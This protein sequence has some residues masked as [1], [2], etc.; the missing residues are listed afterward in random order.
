MF[1]EMFMV[2]FVQNNGNDFLIL[3]V[4]CFR[5]SPDAEQQ[6]HNDDDYH[7]N[8]NSNAHIHDIFEMWMRNPQNYKNKGKHQTDQRQEK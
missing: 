1:F 8:R 4:E 2:A 5:F 3:S 7:D 6:N